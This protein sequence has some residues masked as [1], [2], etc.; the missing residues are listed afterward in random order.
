MSQVDT[1]EVIAKGICRLS[2]IY[3]VERYLM[4]QIFE[5]YGRCQVRRCQ[6]KSKGELTPNMFNNIWIENCEMHVPTYYGEAA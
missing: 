6:M 1:Q 4:E 2:G 5:S 3:G